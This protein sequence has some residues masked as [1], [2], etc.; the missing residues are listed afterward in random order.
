MLISRNPG[1][2]APRE[3]GAIPGRHHPRMRVIQYSEASV[4]ESKARGVL[5]TPHA[6]G[7]TAAWSGDRATM[8]ARERA[9][10]LPMRWIAR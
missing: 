7:K 10:P 3:R 1:A 9:L 5:D 4:M 6:R 8:C 2:S